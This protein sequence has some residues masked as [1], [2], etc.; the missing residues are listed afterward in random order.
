MRIGSRVSAVV[1]ILLFALVALP[2]RERATPTAGAV[3]HATVAQSSS[4][5]SVE[6]RRQLRPAPARLRAPEPSGTEAERAK[7]VAW[8]F[9]LL[10][11]G[12]GAR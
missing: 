1:M 9:L 2:T 8:L 3:E 4:T 11:D 7:T 10:K 12:R 5:P 6:V